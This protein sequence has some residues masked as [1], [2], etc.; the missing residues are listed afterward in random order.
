MCEV[1]ATVIEELYDSMGA[2]PDRIT[3]AAGSMRELQFSVVI[4]V[5]DAVEKLCECLSALAAQQ[6]A[7]AFEVIVVDDGSRVPVMTSAH[8]VFGRLSVQVHRQIPLGISAARNLGISKA[9][10]ETLIFLDSDCLAD[11][12]ML[13]NLERRLAAERKTT[14]FQLALQGGKGC[15]TDRLEGLR[16]GAIQRTTLRSDGRIEYVNTSGFAIRGTELAGA[17]NLFD[18]SVLRGEDSILL[19]KLS[20]SDMLPQF[21]DDVV[22]SHRPGIPFLR[23]L[24]KH[25][26]IGY[27][28]GNARSVLAQRGHGFLTTQSR[29]ETFR[30]IG[31]DARGYPGRVLATLLIGCCYAFERAGRVAHRVFGMKHGRRA[32]LDSV[33]DLVSEREVIARCLAA[34]GRRGMIVSYLTSWTLV[35]AH[36]DPG[37]AARLAAADIVYADGI[38]VVLALAATRLTRCRK[39]TADDFFVELCWGAAQRDLRIAL[40][41]AKESVVERVRL[42]LTKAVPSLNIA[43]ARSGFVA[44]EQRVDVLKDLQTADPAI[45]VLGMGQ[46]LQEEWAELLHEGLP[47]AV[48]YCVGGLFDVIG[49]ELP[50]PP[51]W[52]RR[53]GLEWLYRLG[54]RPRDVWRRYLIGLP[55]LAWIIVRYMFTVAPSRFGHQGDRESVST[56]RDIG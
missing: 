38:G 3:S 43:Y 29:L 36:Q 35:Q 23:Y 30:A 18:V 40:F 21:L 33:V 24:L 19:A 13:A 52:V 56:P 25:F 8:E 16:L 34:A 32:V 28:S 39:V 45:V 22:V 27:Q 10:G 15:L 4:A 55:Q 41:G 5:R 1:E 42:T 44:A 9:S 26:S 12:H 20:Q 49:A 48:I 50:R 14:A 6:N 47:R 31:R 11:P 46:P 17:P 51:I 53:V 37:F 54:T 2:D 7:G